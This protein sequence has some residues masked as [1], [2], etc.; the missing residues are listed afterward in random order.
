MYVVTGVKFISFDKF[1][2]FVCKN[3][4]LKNESISPGLPYSIVL[5]AMNLCDN[6]LFRNSYFTCGNNTQFNKF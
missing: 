2:N 6:A 5:D 1:L 4:K 3:S